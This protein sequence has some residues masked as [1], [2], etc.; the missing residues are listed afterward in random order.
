MES[1]SNN[2]IIKQIQRAGVSEVTFKFDKDSNGSQSPNLE[3]KSVSINSA[4]FEIQEEQSQ[5]DISSSSRNEIRFPW[6]GIYFDALKYNK[7]VNGENIDSEQH[8]DDASAEAL[9]EILESKIARK[10]KCEPIYR[11]LAYLTNYLYDTYDYNYSKTNSERDPQGNY[12]YNIERAI[13]VGI[14]TN[15][16]QINLEETKQIIEAIGEK[17]GDTNKVDDSNFANVISKIACNSRGKEILEIVLKFMNKFGCIDKPAILKEVVNK[18]E[19]IVNKHGDVSVLNELVLAIEEN[20]IGKDILMKKILEQIL[21]LKKDEYERLK[22]DRV[23]NNYGNLFEISAE[24]LQTLITNYNTKKTINA[25][26]VD[27][28]IKEIRN[29]RR[30]KNSAKNM[31]ADRSFTRKPIVILGAAGMIAAAFLSVKTL[32]LNNKSNSLKNTSAEMTIELETE[33]EELYEDQNP[34]MPEALQEENKKYYIVQYKDPISKEKELVY[35]QMDRDEYEIPETDNVIITKDG[36]IEN[37]DRYELTPVLTEMYLNEEG[38]YIYVLFYNPQDESKAEKYTY[39]YYDDEN[40]IY[41]NTIPAKKLS[42]M[43]EG[44]IITEFNDGANKVQLFTLIPTFFTT[45]EDVSAAEQE[46]NIIPS[47]TTFL[48]SKEETVDGEIINAIGIMPKGENDN[49]SKIR[50]A[51]IEGEEI[52]KVESSIDKYENEEIQEDVSSGFTEVGEYT[53]DD[54]FRKLYV[55]S[56]TNTMGIPKYIFGKGVHIIL[57]EYDKDEFNKGF[58]V[59][60]ENKHQGQ[61]S[62]EDGEEIKELI[63]QNYEQ[64]SSNNTETEE[65]YEESKYKEENK[66]TEDTEISSFDAFEEEWDGEEIE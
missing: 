21:D 39:F 54:N 6:Q 9:R 49:Q 10:S 59:A 63:N 41:T 57:Y 3:K 14:K 56:S 11:D 55:Y 32:F 25:K 4:D 2:N 53:L 24:D 38:S 5:E 12:V 47:G 44:D 34:E 46:S 66:D 60:D 33:D 13:I 48:G 7:E 29:K 18:I 23:L 27:D 20:D 40:N 31:G 35:L 22:K 45:K 30:L 28:Y 19:Q 50:A 8:V 1:S 43:E 62:I 26:K 65:E 37:V 17:Y 36:V 42:N 51:R 52:K 15:Y 58:I 61:I 16:L 64:E